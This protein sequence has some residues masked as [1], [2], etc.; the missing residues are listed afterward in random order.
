MYNGYFLFHS[1]SD[2]YRDQLPFLSY[3]Y[4]KK[5]VRAGVQRGYDWY[6][7][8]GHRLMDPAAVTS[9]EKKTTKI[10]RRV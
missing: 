4:A 8:T 9:V 1:Y 2:N 7:D 3:F 10:R 6:E 5:L